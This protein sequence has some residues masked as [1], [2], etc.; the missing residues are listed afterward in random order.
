MEIPTIV[1]VIISLFFIYLILSLIASEIQEEIATFRQ[2]R[3][4]HLK[5][6]IANLL[7]V[8]FTDKLYHHALIKTFAQTNKKPRPRKDI[9]GPV[10]IPSKMFSYALLDILQLDFQDLNTIDNLENKTNIPQEWPE[11]L[12][13][14]LAC[15][16]KRAK[17]QTNEIQTE[18]QDLHQ[19][20]AVW[21][22]E[23][24]DRASG[25]YKRNAKGVS[26]LI[27]LLVAVI[28]NAD[29]IYLMERLYKEEILRS[30]VTQISEQIL[31]KNSDSVIK[32]LN[33][34]KNQQSKENC[35][36]P[37]NDNIATALSQISS[38]PIGWNLANPLK[39]LQAQQSISDVEKWQLRGI[40]KIIFGWLLT[41]VAISMGAPFWF[42]MLNKFVNVRNA[43]KKPHS[44]TE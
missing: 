33:N 38:P 11:E 6:A 42:E 2:W 15:F 44:R 1:N 31:T 5:K 41:A 19:Q 35:L 4:K 30:T 18:I 14:I 29:T 7:D 36:N 43:G 21:F 16:A 20:I 13:D 40:I 28:A 10:Y 12:K 8:E 17:I 27:G 26:F 24:M 39:Q 3:A 32:C 22:D 9:A 23:S 37:L 34:A 25:A